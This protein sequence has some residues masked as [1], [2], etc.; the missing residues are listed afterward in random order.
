VHYAAWGMVEDGSFQLHLLTIPLHAKYDIKR[1]YAMGGFG[2]SFCVAST[3]SSSSAVN[4]QG[5]YCSVFNLFAD[6][7]V[8]FY[9]TKNIS[10][11]IETSLGCT[12]LA[13]NFFIG[14][15]RANAYEVVAGF[16][17]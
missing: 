11:G 14:N 16:R 10:V 1:F 13:K 5:G 3:Y 9:I 17:F 6:I 12:K 7:G 2:L 15:V 8:G 4:P